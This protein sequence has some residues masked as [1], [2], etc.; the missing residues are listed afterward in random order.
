[1]GFESAITLNEKFGS[2][3]AFYKLE[4][5]ERVHTCSSVRKIYRKGCMNAEAD[6][7]IVLSNPGSCRPADKQALYELNPPNTIEV[8]MQKAKANHTE[9]QLMRLMD[10]M[11]WDLIYIIHLT[12]LLSKDPIDLEHDLYF[13]NY[14]RYGGHSIFTLNRNVEIHQ[15]IGSQT[16]IIAGWGTS[17]IPS[18]ASES[19]HS[20]CSRTL[21][22]SMDFPI[23]LYLSIIILIHLQ[24]QVES[25]GLVR[26]KGSYGRRQ[27]YKKKLSKS[28]YGFREF[29]EF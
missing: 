28:T 15:L 13:M 23:K 27:M 5:S 18:G 12:D 7:L 20:K 19:K 14:N 6:A 24:N 1:M 9:Y 2:K 29:F 26:W 3:A 4:V 22:Q 21:E 25:S 16:K 11:V 8:R 10:R 17:E